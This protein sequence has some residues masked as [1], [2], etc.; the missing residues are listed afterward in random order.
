MVYPI[1]TLS[2]RLRDG[3]SER[4]VP[5]HIRALMIEA[6]DAIDGKPTS[7]SSTLQAATV[8]EWLV[9]TGRKKTV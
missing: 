4:F 9:A 6:A 3:A 2:S 8:D 5:K 1:A 7:V